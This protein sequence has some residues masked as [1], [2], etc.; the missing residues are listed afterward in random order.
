ML[1]ITSVKDT[2][3]V[4]NVH[5]DIVMIEDKLIIPEIVRSFEGDYNQHSEVMFER[6]LKNQIIQ[7]S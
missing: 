3:E 6:I 5:S 7:K 1:K 2:A 4:R